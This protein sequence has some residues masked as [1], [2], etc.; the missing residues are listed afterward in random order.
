M[1]TRRAVVTTSNGPFG[2]CWSGVGGACCAGLGSRF[3]G[4]CGTW[5]ER[6]T[7][8]GKK[9]SGEWAWGRGCVAG[10]LAEPVG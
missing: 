4:C 1:R 10:A 2:S 5:A 3:T 9:R 8:N 7:K 6:K